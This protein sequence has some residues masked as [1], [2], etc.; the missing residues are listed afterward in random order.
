[1]EEHHV[2]KWLLS[3]LER[4]DPTDEWFTPKVTVLMENVRHHVRK[5]EH[6]LFPALRSAMDRV[7]LRDLGV[8][9]AEGKRLAPTHPH[10]RLPDTSPGNL[11]ARAVSGAIDRARDT[12][13]AK[14]R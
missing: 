8:R 3:E 2:V 10:P 5:E 12:V 7:E 11:I 6:E 9:L 1:M 14:V 13:A 4:S